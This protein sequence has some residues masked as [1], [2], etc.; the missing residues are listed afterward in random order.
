MRAIEIKFAIWQK[1]RIENHLQNRKSTQSCYCQIEKKNVFSFFLRIWFAEQIIAL[2]FCSILKCS[3]G[4]WYI[5]WHRLSTFLEWSCYIINTFSCYWL[6]ENCLNLN[7][8]HYKSAEILMYALESFLCNRNK[9]FVSIFNV[10][11]LKFSKFWPF[12][13]LQKS[14]VSP[15]II[16]LSE[17]CT[18]LFYISF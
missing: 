2:W 16:S 4:E 11:I 13:L 8:C 12:I 6:Q 9:V 5:A 14:C 15:R 18:S 1:S 17:V 10:N 7:A 3:C